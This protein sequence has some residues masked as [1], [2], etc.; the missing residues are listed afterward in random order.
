MARA[1]TYANEAHEVNPTDGRPLILIG[2]MYAASADQCGDNDFTKKTAYWVAV[3][4]FQQAARAAEDPVVQDRAMQMANIYRQYF[5]IRDDIFFHG[6]SEGES[7]RVGCW[8]N[9]ST[10]IRAR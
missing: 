9:R 8:I 3:D 1:R 7:Y 4:M 5:P 10:T 6:Y 2:E